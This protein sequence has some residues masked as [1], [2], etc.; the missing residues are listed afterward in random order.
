MV[1]GRYFIFGTWTLKGTVFHFKCY[2]YATPNSEE[3]RNSKLQTG[4]ERRAPA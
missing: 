2:T 3:L 1:L 4:A